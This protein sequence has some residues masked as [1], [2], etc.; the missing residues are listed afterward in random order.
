VIRKKLGDEYIDQMNEYGYGL[1]A[2][3]K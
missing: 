2:H 3:D 1:L